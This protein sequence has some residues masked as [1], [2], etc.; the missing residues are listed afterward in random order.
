M[1]PDLKARAHL[2]ESVKVTPMLMITKNKQT[3]D[4]NDDREGRSN[5][6]TSRSLG[7]CFRQRRGQERSFWRGIQV[8]KSSR[9]KSKSSGTRRSVGKE[10]SRILKLITYLNR[11]AKR[12]AQRK[13]E[14]KT[15]FSKKPYKSNKQHK[16][17]KPLRNIWL[18]AFHSDIEVGYN[19][20]TFLP[21]A[22]SEIREHPR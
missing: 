6:K 10:I 12:Q 5:R 20:R 8:M 9:C 18:N 15:G 13:A 16:K 19:L 14:D 1:L 3:N 7:R 11:N 17:Q 2:L 4:R 22:M 21:A